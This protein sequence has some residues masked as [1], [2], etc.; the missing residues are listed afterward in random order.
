MHLFAAGV[1]DRQTSKKLKRLN[2]AACAAVHGSF[3]SYAKL[4]ELLRMAAVV[5]NWWPGDCESFAVEPQ[6]VV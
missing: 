6:V 5:V 4:G 1:I 3:V 2:D